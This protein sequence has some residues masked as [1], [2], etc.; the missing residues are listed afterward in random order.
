MKRLR[1]AIAASALLAFSC[2]GSDGGGSLDA[3]GSD[4]LL[5]F[6]V[7]EVPPGCPPATGN[8]IGIGGL[9]T[10]NG[11]ECANGLS[12][13]CDDRLGFAMPV[14]MP[15]FCTNPAVGACA[16]TNPSCGTNAAC[17]EFPVTATTLVSGCFPSV[18]LFDNKCPIISWPQG[19]AGAAPDAKSDAANDRF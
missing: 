15:C 12:C 1:G 17:C 9:C 2:H 14:G 4:A 5:T 11:H 19:D 16:Y 3:P 6:M 8:N 7:P 10:R 13:L 18:C